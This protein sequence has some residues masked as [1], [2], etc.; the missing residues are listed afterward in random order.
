VKAALP[1]KMKGSDARLG[2]VGVTGALDTGGSSPRA[3][4]DAIK[5]FSARAGAGVPEGVLDAGC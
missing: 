5:G 4:S 1:G 2:G 3:L